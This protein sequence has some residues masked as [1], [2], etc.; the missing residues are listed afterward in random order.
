MGKNTKNDRVQSD[1]R[2][3]MDESRRRSD[4]FDKYLKDLF[5]P[6]YDR[7]Q[8]YSGDA[9]G[10]FGDVYGRYGDMYGSY[11]DV[12]KS[13]FRDEYNK[14]RGF[15]QNLMDTGGFSD[16]EKGEY[17]RRSLAPAGSMWSNLKNEYENRNRINPYNTG[18]S[19]GQSKLARNAGQQMGELG[20]GAETNLSQMIR[21]GKLAGAGGDER[22][23]GAIN[24]NRLAGMGGQMGALGGQLGA[25]QGISGLA[26]MSADFSKGLLGDMLSNRSMDSQTRAALLSLLAQMNPRVS[27]W[28][29]IMQIGKLLTGGAE[30]IMGGQK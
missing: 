27:N 9:Y 3:E 8:Q 26:G 5:G 21:E 18:Y 12:A 22:I 28:D 24:Q 6:E 1:A 7:Y 16:K 23:A 20:I 14:S 25:T 30:A 2:S 15:Y 11:G 17:R 19:A 29:R 4:E 10:K 13:G